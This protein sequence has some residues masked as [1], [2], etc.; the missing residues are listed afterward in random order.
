[1]ALSAQVPTT[2]S[3]DARSALEAYA[4]AEKA[5]GF[6]PRAGLAGPEDK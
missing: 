2:L 4:A 6:N 1:M 3:E 5:T